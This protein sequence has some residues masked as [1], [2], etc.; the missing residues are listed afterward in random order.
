M[1]VPSGLSTR[2]C[3]RSEFFS[4]FPRFACLQ[5]SCLRN[6][7]NMQPRDWTWIIANF[8]FR[9]RTKENPWRQE[10]FNVTNLPTLIKVSGEKVSL[11]SL[12]VVTRVW[13]TES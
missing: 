13:F 11:A 7:T 1:R 10:P 8:D 9:W 3:P 12:P 4:P 5:R 2:G 6:I